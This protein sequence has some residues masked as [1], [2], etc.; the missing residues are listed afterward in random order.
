MNSDGVT[1]IR[2]RQCIKLSYTQYGQGLKDPL[3]LYDSKGFG[4]HTR[5]L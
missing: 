4:D 5:L 2:Q 1:E 3:I